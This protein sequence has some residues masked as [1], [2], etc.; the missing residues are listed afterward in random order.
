MNHERIDHTSNR[1][2]ATAPMAGRILQRKCACGQ[3]TSGGGKCA[4][5]S[6]K[7][8]LKQPL[9]AKL[10][11]GEA[12]DSY[13]READR[14]AE[15]VMRM[16]TPGNSETNDYL[17]AKPLVQRRTANSQSAGTE[18]PSIV[19]EVLG[20][21]GSPLDQTT[22]DYMEPRFGFD[23][24]QVR[25]HNDAKAAQS[26]KVVNALAYTVGHN[27]VLGANLSAQENA[28][29]RRV[30]A[31]ELTHV[32][33]QTAEPVKPSAAISK[34]AKTAVAL[35]R[36]TPRLQRLGA[37]PGC[38]K[39]QAD[40]IHQAIFDAKDWVRKALTALAATPLAQRTLRALTHNFGAS[41]TAANAAA[42]ATTLGAGRNDMISIPFSCADATEAE[43]AQGHC[44]F[45]PPAAGSHAVVICT[46]ITL[47]RSKAIYRG[48]CVLHE[49]MHASDASMTAAADSYSGWF[50][51][52]GS[53]P[54]YPGPS[55]LANADSYTTLAMELS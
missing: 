44:G 17:Q 10:Q 28:S 51:H 53:T 25:V 26:A 34:P 40:Q 52:S 2:Q 31:H 7:E 9:Q 12:N 27:I 15:Q 39:G 49:A 48:G 4:A 3:H 33:Q 6:D 20:S 32:V 41:G 38:T 24:S 14:V 22:R 36:I 46:N 11:I 37:N 47:T 18:V 43:C 8:K 55:P 21:S 13:E 30:L 54:G 16:P 19:H 45:A 29:Q 5:C 23:F 50:G 42:I 1:L 35:Q